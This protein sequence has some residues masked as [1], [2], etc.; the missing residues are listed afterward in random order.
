MSQFINL[1]WSI[2]AGDSAW[3][4]P[5]R[6]E[7][8]E[9][10][11]PRNPFFSH[12][13]V[14]FWLAFRDGCPIGRISAQIDH[15]HLERY[16]DATGFFGLLEAE[17]N[18][19]CFEALLETA[20]D[21]LR[22]RGMRR[23]RGPFNLS[24]NQEC[25]LLV[26]GF[27]TPPRIMMGHARHYYGPMV[28]QCGYAKAK[29][30]LAY[31]IRADFE[32][33]S[34]LPSLAKRFSDQVH[35]RPLNKSR[36]RED[37]KIIQDIFEDAWSENWGFVPFTED[38]IIALGKNLKFLVDEEM[39]RIAEV[40]GEPAA[41]MVVFPNIN[42][43]IADLNGRLLPFGWLKLLWRIKVSYP[44]SLRVPLMGVRKKY[45]KSRLGAA[46]ALMMITELQVPSLKRK[47]REAEM[48]WILED[49][50]GMKSIIEAIGGKAYK[51]YRIFQKDII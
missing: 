37:L 45:Q 40:D 29:D 49:N 18:L 25:G 26:E 35:L 50:E 19:D 17:E 34:F 4:P 5:L 6:H 15:L 48:S 39:V 9:L 27:S 51:R 16:N 12:A 20:E 1:P 21:W 24:I 46:L 38:E 2:Y 33:P 30:L 41:M 43:A 3:I 22:S 36:F 44:T 23:V 42:E 8:K 32:H 14:R 28:E 47:V 7:R 11:S 31:N 10:L 13:D